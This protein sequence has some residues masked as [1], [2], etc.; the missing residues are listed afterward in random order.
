MNAQ[1]R[2]SILSGQRQS[3]LGVLSLLRLEPE[4]QLRLDNAIEK[5]YTDLKFHQ[6][7]RSRVTQSPPSQH[8]PDPQKL[9]VVC[10]IHHLLSSIRADFYETWD[11]EF[12]LDTKS[13]E[14]LDL[15]SRQK[16]EAGGN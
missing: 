14:F 7:L 13:C 16:C 3:H 4:A 6:A 5:A 15:T 2:Y 10:P 8:S 1:T 11:T 9:Q 12:P